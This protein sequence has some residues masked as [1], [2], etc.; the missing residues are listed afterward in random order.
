[1]QRQ[2]ES[3]FRQPRSNNL[4]NGHWSVVNTPQFDN[5]EQDIR[6]PFAGET[7]WAASDATVR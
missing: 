2:P 4:G 1:M 7:A 5:D 3:S 6:S